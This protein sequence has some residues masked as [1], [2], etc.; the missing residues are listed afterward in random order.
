MSSL[1]AR[2]LV[3][4]IF[5]ASG[6]HAGLASRA[7]LLVRSMTPVP[8]RFITYTSKLPPRSLENA[9]FPLAPSGAAPAPYGTNKTPIN[10]AVKAMVTAAR[11]QPTRARGSADDKSDAVAHQTSGEGGRVR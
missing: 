1:P 6:D 7:G 11:C 3:K 10:R 8:S 4:A 5:A 2:S 9:I